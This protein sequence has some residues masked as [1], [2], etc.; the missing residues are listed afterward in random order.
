MSGG[1]CL[2]NHMPRAAFLCCSRAPCGR[3]E[4]SSPPRCQLSVPRDVCFPPARRVHMVHLPF[5]G[6]KLR[7]VHFRALTLPLLAHFPPSLCLF[8]FLAD[9][10]SCITAQRELHLCI[11]TEDFVWICPRCGAMWIISCHRWLCRVVTY[12]RCRVEICLLFHDFLKY[13]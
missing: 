10:L 1:V 8:L 12:W 3:V 6:D 11:A 9:R 13:I 4:T 7:L 2:H 5:T